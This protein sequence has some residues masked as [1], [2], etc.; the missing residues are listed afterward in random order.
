[1]SQS[2]DRSF[3]KAL[4]TTPL[5]RRMIDDIKIRKMSVLT[6]A[7]YVRA[8]KNFAAFHGKSPDTLSF[9]DVQTYQ[10]HLLSRV[11]AADAQ[12]D[13]LCTA[14]LLRRD[15]AQAGRQD[16]A[17]ARPPCGHAASPAVDRR[18]RLLPQRRRRS[19]APRR[20]RDGLCR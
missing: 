9:E 8:V 3:P 20:V 13:H 15:P 14:V 11:A 19:Q 18:G 16:R 1:M 17:S 2:H 10:L 5:R 12:P 4:Q 6:Q 7:A